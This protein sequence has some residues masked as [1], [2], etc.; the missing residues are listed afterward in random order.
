M[1]GTVLADEFAEV[2]GPF[3][4]AL[5]VVG[6]QSEVLA[7]PEERVDLLAVGH[8]SAGGEAAFGVRFPLA[9]RGRLRPQHLPMGGVQAEEH[10][11]LGIARRRL[12][13][14]AIAPDDR[15]RMAGPRQR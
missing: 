9:A 2:P 5:E 10:S 3:E 15:R 14:D 1:P 11:L 7:V 12:K 6:V 13:E 8:G 4:I